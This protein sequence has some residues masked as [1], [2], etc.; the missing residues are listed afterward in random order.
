MQSKS[1]RALRVREMLLL[2]TPRLAML[3]LVS[4]LCHVG[5]GAVA[6]RRRA[7]ISLGSACALVC[8][9]QPCQQC[10]EWHRIWARVA[11]ANSSR[12]AKTGVAPARAVRAVPFGALLVR[13]STQKLPI[14]YILEQIGWERIGFLSTIFI[15]IE[16]FLSF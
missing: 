14:Q 5:R 15:A 9:L 1:F 16:H 7:I 12:P 2:A 13:S 10:S 8:T 6:S 11:R 4:Y 3:L